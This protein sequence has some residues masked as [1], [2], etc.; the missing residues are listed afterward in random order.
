MLAT[1]IINSQQQN[2]RDLPRADWVNPLTKKTY[3]LPSC[4]PSTPKKLYPFQTKILEGWT[5]D[6]IRIFDWLFKGVG[7]L[8]GRRTIEKSVENLDFICCSS[9][10]NLCLGSINLVVKVVRYLPN[11]AWVSRMA[12]CNDG[13]C[14]FWNENECLHQ[15]IYRIY[16]EHL[17]VA[18]MGRIPNPCGHFEE[19]VKI[20]APQTKILEGWKKDEIQIFDWLFNGS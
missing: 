1:W 20:Y 12:T 6:E 10:Q 14:N 7:T 17:V 11:P 3:C 19:F 13:M 5:K 4:G 8:F 16:I 18:T 15:D 9:F 2:L